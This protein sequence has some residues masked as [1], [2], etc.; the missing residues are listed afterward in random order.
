MSTNQTFIF[1]PAVLWKSFR[2]KHT[3]TKVI[4]DQ[5]EHEHITHNKLSFPKILPLPIQGFKA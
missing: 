5:T 4:R 1:L 2:L 3:E